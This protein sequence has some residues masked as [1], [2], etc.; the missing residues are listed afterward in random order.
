M[1][2]V[3]GTVRM[4]MPFKSLSA[5]LELRRIKQL[6]E[7]KNNHWSINLT[8]TSESGIVI[9]FIR[10][11]IQNPNVNYLLCT[12]SVLGQTESVLFT[13]NLLDSQLQ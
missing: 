8:G 3:K 5:G 10:I 2:P 7:F 6:H 1:Q 13:Q 11:R 4:T 9:R 12:R